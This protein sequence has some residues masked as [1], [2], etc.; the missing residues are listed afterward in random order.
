MKGACL[1]RRR[2]TGAGKA[3]GG[4]KS[5]KYDQ[6]RKLL[7]GLVLAIWRKGNYDMNP[8]EPF[9]VALL[10]ALSRLFSPARAPVAIRRPFLFERIAIESH[11]RDGAAFRSWLL[12]SFAFPCSSSSRSRNSVSGIATG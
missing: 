12:T 9:L 3:E 4:D 6:L 7:G 8:S 2:S 10:Y 11:S 1:D 5:Y